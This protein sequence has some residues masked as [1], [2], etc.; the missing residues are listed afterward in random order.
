MSDNSSP[1]RRGPKDRHIDPTNEL[2]GVIRNARIAKNLT[3]PEVCE[4]VGVS[5]A[6]VTQTEVGQTIPRKPT[7]EK[8]EK[9]LGFTAGTLLAI[10]EREI[11]KRRAKKKSQRLS[12]WGRNLLLSLTAKL[13]EI[14]FLTQAERAKKLQEWLDGITENLQSIPAD[15]GQPKPSIGDQKPT[16]KQGGESSANERVLEAIIVFST[17]RQEIAELAENQHVALP[18][19]AGQLLVLGLR[20]YKRQRRSKKKGVA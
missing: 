1:D 18:N 4:L 11:K 16:M 3:T 20:A 6:S 12:Q 15:S 14:E 9:V 2:G 17:T 19:F 10:R 7:L 8:Y 13:K 5:D